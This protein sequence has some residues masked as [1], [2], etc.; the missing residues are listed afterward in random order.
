VADSPPATKSSKWHGK[1]VNLNASTRRSGSLNLSP[2]RAFTLNEH[3]AVERDFARFPKQRSVAESPHAHMKTRHA[4]PCLAVALSLAIFLSLYS[5]VLAEE[6]E[7]LSFL[8]VG[9]SYDVAYSGASLRNT[10]KILAPAGGQWFRVEVAPRRGGAPGEKPEQPYERWVNFAN[11]VS[12]KEAQEIVQNSS[13]TAAET[14]PQ[15][16]PVIALLRAVKEKD[17]KQLQSAF[18]EK[19][20]AQYDKQGWDKVLQRYEEGFKKAF[21]DYKV[22]D[23]AFAYKGDGEKGEVSVAH[24]DKTHPGMSV[25]KEKAEWK[26]DER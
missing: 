6:P 22:Q 3:C 4:L 18:S 15:A 26:L 19:M 20:R 24:K 5:S 23:F 1:L 21:G 14:I 10:V 8:K 13:A 16:R 2:K 17:Q 7:T 25:I 9:R 11:V 12:V